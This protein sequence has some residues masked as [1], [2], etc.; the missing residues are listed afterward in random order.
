M[1]PLAVIPLKDNNG[2]E[3]SYLESFASTCNA[4]MIYTCNENG[5]K[6]A[7]GLFVTD[8]FY[9]T[10]GINPEECEKYSSEGYDESIANGNW[11]AWQEECVTEEATEPEVKSEDDSEA[12]KANVIWVYKVKKGK[13]TQDK[14]KKP[15]LRE[16]KRSLREIKSMNVAY[17][18]NRKHHVSK[19]E[20]VFKVTVDGVKKRRKKMKCIDKTFPVLTCIRGR[21]FDSKFTVK[22]KMLKV[23]KFIRTSLSVT[24][25]QYIALIFFQMFVCLFHFSII[26]LQ[27]DVAAGNQEYQGSTAYIG[28]Q[29]Y[30]WSIMKRVF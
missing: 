21:V 13:K 30:L 5:E 24:S 11:I 9:R 26:F 1:K 20:K 18:E 12:C 25:V 17:A 22:V 14:K 8:S 15:T 7:V 4:E 3:I 28:M 27:G 2:D 6:V 29:K 23:K 16:I 19:K 10:S